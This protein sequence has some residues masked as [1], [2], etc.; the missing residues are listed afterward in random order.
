MTTSREPITS[1][2]NSRFR[3]LLSLHGSRGVR[4]EGSALISG[5]RLV[6]ELLEQHPEKVR[7]LVS[8]ARPDFVSTTDTDAFADELEAPAGWPGERLEL[9]PA[10]FR[11]LDLLGTG[12][13]LAVAHVEEPPTW[14][15][16]IE[17]EGIS[18][19]LP[20]GDPENLGAALR[21]S[22]GFGA[23]AVVLLE[24]A[25][26][27]FHPRAIRASAGACFSLKLQR[28]PSLAELLREP[29]DGLIALDA[30]G[31]PIDQVTLEPPLGLVI[32]EEGRGLPPL[33]EGVATV[34]I[35]IDERLE[36]LNAAVA[37]GVALW[38][39]RPSSDA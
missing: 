26:H 37:T 25:A 3:R 16:A 14:A 4:R 13:P 38:A 33:P 1:A 34:S 22:L 30:A 31:D 19:F 35:P 8:P 23:S 10:L 5:R 28:G 6:S 2:S 20:F 24:E 15:G 29:P 12:A 11:D 17:P 18:L 32:G 27:P 9:A 39:L 7:L 36:S 21:S